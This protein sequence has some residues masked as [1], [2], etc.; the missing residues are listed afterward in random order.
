MFTQY[1]SEQNTKSPTFIFFFHSTWFCTK[2][3][4]IK[5]STC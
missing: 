1:G 2:Y 5:I 3:Y 4:V